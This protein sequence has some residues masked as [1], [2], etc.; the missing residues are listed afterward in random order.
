MKSPVSVTSEAAPSAC[1]EAEGSFDAAS[2]TM[3]PAKGSPPLPLKIAFFTTLLPL[4][5]VNFTTAHVFLNTSS[6]LVVVATDGLRP[7]AKLP[8]LDV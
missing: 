4:F 7:L 1:T 5:S 2:I 3:V 6:L 8:A